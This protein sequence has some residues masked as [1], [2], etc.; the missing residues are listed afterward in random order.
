MQKNP[1]Q[2]KPSGSNSSDTFLGKRQRMK[3]SQKLTHCSY[4]N[5]SRELDFVDAVL[6]GVSDVESLISVGKMTSTVSGG[7]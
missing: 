1:H 4:L 5:R 2:P 6:G 7:K 3:Q